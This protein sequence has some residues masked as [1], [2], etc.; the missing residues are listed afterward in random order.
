MVQ[1]VVPPYRV[2][3]VEG[4]RSRLA[5]ENIDLVLVSGDG[6]RRDGGPNTPPPWATLIPIRELKFGSAH[7]QY[8]PILRLARTADLLIAEQASKSVHV[9]WRVLVPWTSRPPVALWGHGINLQT[10]RRSGLGERVK[11]RATRRSHWFFA[12]T[13]GTAKIVEQMGLEPSRITTL[14][15][16]I[17]TGPLVRAVELERQRSTVH[18]HRA[19][20]VGRLY[21]LKR[22][23]FLL[24]AARLI[25][26]RLPDFELVVV[27]D[28]PS[29]QIVADAAA[30]TPWITHHT[31]TIGVAVA[32]HLATASL[33]LLPGLV[34]LAAVD[35]ILCGLPSV[36]VAD[37]EHSPEFEYLADGVTAVVLPRDAS[38]AAYAAAVVELL[39]DPE[40]LATMAANCRAAD[41]EL[42]M[43]RMIDDFTNGVLAALQR[44]A[45]G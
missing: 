10:S 24:E 11:L 29:S 33:M 28:G 14:H 38:P 1:R 34:G 41:R 37:Q 8:Q 18:P 15:N 9:M 19:I 20:Y 25:R 13:P 2:P 7:V 6:Q 16:T 26:D 32:P 31:D 35:A 36:V 23:D 5:A 22:P 12:Y 43:D 17:D 39:T 21:E 42:S 44:A 27:G 45:T 3:L 30:T 4:V 40:R